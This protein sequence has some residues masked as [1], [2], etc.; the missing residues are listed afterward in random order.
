MK[1]PR[2][3][4]AISV[5]VLSNR[6]TNRK[7]KTTVTSPTLSAPR[8]VHLQEHRRDRRR[9]VEDAAELLLAGDDRDDGH[10]QDADDHAAH[11]RGGTRAPTISDE[12]QGRHQRPASS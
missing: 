6:S 12:A 4:S 7:A 8:E 9:H 11:A 10:G 2:W 1:P 3:A 5:P